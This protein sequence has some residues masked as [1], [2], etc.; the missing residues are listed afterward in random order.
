MS[1]I[2]MRV[3]A[4]M[5]VKEHK[6]FKTYKVLSAV[7]NGQI[8]LE[9]TIFMDFRIG[10]RSTCQMVYVTPDFMIF[11]HKDCKELGVIDQT[12]PERAAQVNKCSASGDED[13]TCTCPVRGKVPDPAR[14]PVGASPEKLE[15]FIK[16]HYASLAFNMCEKQKQKL[17]NG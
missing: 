11:S 17:S 7:N 14:R 4:K 12:F 3:V 10:N 1:I 6:L 8:T 5:G 16:N 2:G 15:K 13:D 9:G